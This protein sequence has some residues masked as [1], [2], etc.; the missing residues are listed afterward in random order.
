MLEYSHRRLGN[1]PLCSCLV[2][3]LPLDPE[4]FGADVCLVIH[5]WTFDRDCRIAVVRLSDLV[6]LL[7]REIVL[8]N[9]WLVEESGLDLLAVE[10]SHG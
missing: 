1:L 2:Q 5:F 7:E 9:G 10:R 3:V 6:L 4:S 8:K